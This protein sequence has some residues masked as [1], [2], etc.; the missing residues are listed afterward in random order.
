MPSPS[1]RLA[2]AGV[3]LALVLALAAISPLFFDRNGSDADRESSGAAAGPSGYVDWPNFGRV[4]QRTHYLPA[5]ERALDPPLKQAWSINTHALIEFPPAVHDGV[6]YVI[7]KY[8]NGK[9]V[10]LEDRKVL[11]EINIRPSDRG[12]PNFVTAP[13][14]YEGRIYGAFLTGHLAAGD[15]ATGKKD[16]VRKF[17]AHLESTP[18]AVDGTLYLGTD[19]T[20]LIA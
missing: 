13:V 9:A 6:A 7:N 19:T 5:T 18:L 10:R 15:A 12:K 1:K 14:Y 4:P 17:D 2:V 3:A 11:W 8:G 20:D 16:W